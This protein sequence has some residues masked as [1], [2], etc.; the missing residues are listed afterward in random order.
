MIHVQA[1]TVALML[2]VEA[3]V[4]HFA[5]AIAFPAVLLLLV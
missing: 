2:Y 5:F 3:V 4:A 1:P